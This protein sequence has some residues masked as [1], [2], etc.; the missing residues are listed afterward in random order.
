MK[1]ATVGGRLYANLFATERLVTV[2]GRL[3]ATTGGVGALPHAV[4]FFSGAEFGDLAD[5]DALKENAIWGGAPTAV[6]DIKHAGDYSMRVYMPATGQ[7]YGYAIA[8]FRKADG[9]IAAE[10]DYDDFYIGW[11]FRTA[12]PPSSICPICRCVGNYEMERCP[13]VNYRTDGKLE[14]SIAATT[15]V[16]DDVLPLNRSLY[17]ELHVVHAGGNTSATLRVNEQ[18]VAEV[19]DVAY[20]Y[21]IIGFWLGANTCAAGPITLW[22]DDV[23]ACTSGWPGMSECSKVNKPVGIGTYN[24]WGQYP[25][26]GNKYDKVDEL[27]K[28]ADEDATY[29]LDAVAGEKQTFSHDG[30]GGYKD[31]TAILGVSIW[32][33]SKAGTSSPVQHMGKSSGAEFLSADQTELTYGW[34][35]PLYRSH[36]PNTGA[37]WTEAAVDAL[38]AGVK[39]GGANESRAT[40]I[41]VFVHYRRKDWYLGLSG[42]L[43]AAGLVS[44]QTSMATEGA[45]A[46]SGALARMTSVSKVGGITPTGAL[47]RIA[48]WYRSLAGALTP[49]GSLGRLGN[50][51]KMLTG[52]LGL[53]GTVVRTSTRYLT[54]TLISSATLVRKTQRL[55]AGTFTSSGQVIANKLVGIIYKTVTG[56]LNSSGALIRKTQRSTAGILTSVGNLASKSTRFK[57][58][59]GALSAAGALGRKTQR[60]IGG[61]LTSAGTLVAKARKSLSGALQ[62]TGAISTTLYKYV[63]QKSLSGALAL[64]GVVVGRAGKVLAGSLASAGAIARVPTKALVG[65]LTTAGSVIALK[66]TVSKLLAGTLSSS[67]SLI[68]ATKKAVTGALTSTGTLAKKSTRSVAGTLASSGSLVVNKLVS[69]VYKTLSGMLT[70]TGMLVRKS[71]INLV[72]VLTSTGMVVKKTATTLA[73]I[74]T[75]VGTL[76]PITAWYKVLVGALSTTGGV[77]TKAGKALTGTLST[78]GT[79]AT[80]VYKYTTQL[81]L[82]GAMATSGALSAGKAA[83]QSLSGTLSSSGIVGGV[84]TRAQVLAGTLAPIGT[85]SRFV[86]KSLVGILSPAG[87]IG[88]AI[89]RSLAGV[90]GTLGKILAQFVF[91]QV[92]AKLTINDSAMTSLAI[93]D[94][95]VAQA[96]ASD[97]ATASLTIN[98][99][100]VT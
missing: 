14:V 15:D 69:I 59:A 38:E 81:A 6:S 83:L 13:Y 77:V 43:G 48:T 75:S 42:S 2:G 87:S 78:A 25:G 66:G 11:W 99:V 17:L 71:T 96:V 51:Y 82:A 29:I 68:G 61:T 26:T 37:A 44:R 88:K 8:Y 27:P 92:P 9:S 35:L 76:V 3:Y 80:T 19:L 33:R 41:G 94:V 85:S 49:A 12:N 93:G 72:G 7:E 39:A 16:A 79:L 97:A 65:M 70:P 22:F 91:K 34:R 53:T 10:G 24:Q 21:D 55:L 98:D 95:Q 18:V 54:G 23:I 32:V 47:T 84:L 46:P 56:A 31:R 58:L 36:D 60:A 63:T 5:W 57:A 89:F 86:Q 67:G 64:S 40:T 100:G 74:L 45:T 52:T 62:A 28:D 30:L 1:L 20:D 90:L 50:F 4:L 73:G